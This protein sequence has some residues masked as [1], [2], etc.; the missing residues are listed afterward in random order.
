METTKSKQCGLQTANSQRTQNRVCETEIFIILNKKVDKAKN[1]LYCWISMGLCMA[2][3]KTSDRVFT[4]RSRQ[5]PKA[6]SCFIYKDILSRYFQ[7]F[8]ELTSSVKFAIYKWTTS[9]QEGGQIEGGH[10]TIQNN[11][12]PATTQFFL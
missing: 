3:T 1:L 7:K 10:M 4:T 8:Y 5:I 12:L 11:G 2:V 6:L 9:T